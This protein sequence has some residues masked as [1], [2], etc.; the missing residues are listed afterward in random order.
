MRRNRR[1]HDCKFTV[2]IM[3]DLGVIC[4][5]HHKTHDKAVG[6]AH[7]AAHRWGRLP[8]FRADLTLWSP[9]GEIHYEPPPRTA[10]DHIL[11]V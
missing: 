3:A 1:R 8:G 6:V 7:I 4:E 9:E 10:W 11:A 5:S 2:T